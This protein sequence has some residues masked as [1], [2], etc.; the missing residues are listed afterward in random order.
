MRLNINSFIDNLIVL[1]LVKF[2]LAVAT[3]V[4]PQW[5][6]NINTLKTEFDSFLLTNTGDENID[7]EPWKKS[8]LLGSHICSTYDIQQRCLLGNVAFNNYKNV[9]LQG[10]SIALNQL[11][12]VYEAMVVSVIMYN[13]SS[14]AAP[15]DILKKLDVCHRKHLR[16]ILKIRFP[17]TISNIK[18]YSVCSKTP[19]SDRVKL[20][21]W[22]MNLL[23][24]VTK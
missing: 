3:Q 16:Q 22:K 23:N 10:R 19:L 9:W 4:L 1:P 7:L 11:I 12:Q 2:I 20:A 24:T 13:C 17:N 8:I 14:W 15:C 6:L 18:L 21:R 5:S